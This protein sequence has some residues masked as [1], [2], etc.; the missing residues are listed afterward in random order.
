VTELRIVP[1]HVA[2]DILYCKEK[3]DKQRESSQ[4]ISAEY[5]VIFVV[6]IF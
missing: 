3:L 6:A 5:G 1:G 2:P 4:L